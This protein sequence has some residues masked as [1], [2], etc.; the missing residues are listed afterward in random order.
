MVLEGALLP[1]W[2]VCRPSTQVKIEHAVHLLQLAALNLFG[3]AEAL[4][5]IEF[6][7]NG[8]LH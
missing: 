8:E 7:S 4:F 1:L 5:D 6:I 2:L 3:A